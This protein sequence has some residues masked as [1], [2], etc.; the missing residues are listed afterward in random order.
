VLIFY[1]VGDGLGIVIFYF[2]GDGLRTTVA[3]IFYFVGGDD[4][5]F[6]RTIV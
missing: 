3:P 2:P 4:I 6:I 1:F 5:C